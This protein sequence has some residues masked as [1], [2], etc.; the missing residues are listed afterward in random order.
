MDNLL[1][2]LPLTIIASRLEIY[3][4]ALTVREG[5][6]NSF[7]LYNLWTCSFRI[8]LPPWS[9]LY[10]IDEIQYLAMFMRE[11]VN[12]LVQASEYYEYF[13]DVE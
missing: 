10:F 3:L 9:H 11:W 8:S 6:V 12:Q 2:M 1:T 7:S 5:P 4:I 13:I